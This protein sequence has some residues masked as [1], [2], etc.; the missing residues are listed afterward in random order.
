LEESDLV[1]DERHLAEV[2][3][4]EFIEGGAGVAVHEP[5]ERRHH[6]GGSVVHKVEL[7]HGIQ[8]HEMC[9]GTSEPVVKLRFG[10]KGRINFN[11]TDNHSDS[12][13]ALPQT[14]EF[15]PFTGPEAARRE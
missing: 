1:F 15:R 7:E 8:S 11:S 6:V 3:E 10:L 5:F 4:V 2:Q 14:L 9:F 12:G 13:W